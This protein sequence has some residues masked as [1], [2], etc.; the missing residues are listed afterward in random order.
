MSSVDHIHS[1][2]IIIC[3]RRHI[4]PSHCS[5]IPSEAEKQPPCHSHPSERRKTNRQNCTKGPWMS[6]LNTI[7]GFFFFVAVC[8]TRSRG[9]R[10]P[11]RRSRVPWTRRTRLRPGRSPRSTSRIPPGPPETGVA[12]S[13]APGSGSG[14]GLQ[15]GEA[16][17]G[18]HHANK[19]TTTKKTN[20]GRF[21][22]SRLRS[23]SPSAHPPARPSRSPRL[24]VSPLR[25]AA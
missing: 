9:A 12:W 15:D 5:L 1:S 25:S 2:R 18:S 6:G 23:P 3:L 22:A 7:K 16:T 4:F 19:K 8:P 10:P 14:R 24:G 11:P 20:T 21:S 17:W 13:S